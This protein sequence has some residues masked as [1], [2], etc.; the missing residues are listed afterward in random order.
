MA[1]KCRDCKKWKGEG[2]FYKNK[3]CEDGLQNICIVCYAK[4]Y[5]QSIIDSRIRR[6]AESAT[7][8]PIGC[9]K[10]IKRGDYGTAGL[11]KLHGPKLEMA[12]KAILN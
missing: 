8:I 9:D 3:Y 5:R 1:K 12:I 7:S 2:R 11:S 4:R 6:A 10:S